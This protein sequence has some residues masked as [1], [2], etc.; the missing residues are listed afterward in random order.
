MSEPQR[1]RAKAATP[2]NG[3]HLNA[4]PARQGRYGRPVFLVLVVSTLLAALA[5]AAAWFWK[6]PDF[7]AA[8]NGNGPAKSGQSYNAPTPPPPD[9]RP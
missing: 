8:N 4:T 1:P 2:G 3:P 5:L 6:A 7:H 9:P